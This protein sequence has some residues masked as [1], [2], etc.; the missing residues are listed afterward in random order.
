[1]LPMSEMT[2]RERR[3]EQGEDECRIQA[4]EVDECRRQ[5]DHRSQDR[6]SGR[7]LGKHDG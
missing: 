1:M 5:E 3:N 7:I 6:G 2:N 4:N